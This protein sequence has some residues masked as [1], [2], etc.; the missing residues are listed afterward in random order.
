MRRNI[1]IKILFLVLCIISGNQSVCALPQ[2]LSVGVQEKPYLSIFFNNEN[3]L[4]QNTVFDIEKDD[5]GFLWIATEEGMVRYDGST[6]TQFKKDN[7]PEIISN[8][9]YDVHKVEN[10]GVWAA[11]DNSLVLF[12][13]RL[14]KVIDVREIIN[15]NVISSISKDDFGR[16]WVGTLGDLLYYLEDDELKVFKP[17]TTSVGRKIRMIDVFRDMLLVGTNQGLFQINLKNNNISLVNGSD[18][19][20]V[21]TILPQ[22]NEYFIGTKNN[23]IYHFKN[24]ELQPHNLNHNFNDAYVNHIALDKNNVLWAGIADKGLYLSDQGSLQKLDIH[25]LDENLI[26]SIFIDGDHIWLGTTGLGMIHLKPASIQ[27]VKSKN[28][29]IDGSIFPIYQHTNGD[30][31]AGGAGKVF[32]TSLEIIPY[33]IQKQMD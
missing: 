30:I 26:R 2:Q 10:E 33:C 20:D 14:I 24:N 5:F 11:S 28:I 13:K 9:F 25:G 21:F 8:I 1:F 22:E 17:W 19:F 3:G 6:F 16:L 15:D 23:G 18:D 31:F 29:E 4:P 32:I 12:N 27:M 7:T